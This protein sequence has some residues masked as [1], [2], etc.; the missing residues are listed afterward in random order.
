[1]LK[2][3]EDITE[4]MSKIEMLLDTYIHNKKAEV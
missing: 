2:M 1:M 4:V 3:M